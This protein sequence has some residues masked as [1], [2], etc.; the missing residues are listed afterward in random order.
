M[1]ITRA[2]AKACRI[3]FSWVMALSGYETTPAEEMDGVEQPRRERPRTVTVVPG[4][5]PQNAGR[6]F[7][8]DDPA[9]SPFWR[10]KIVKRDVKAGKTGDRT[11]TLH[12][13]TA[14]DGERFG[15]FDTKVDELIVANEGAELEIAWELSGKGNKN[16]TEVRPVAR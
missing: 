6:G 9:E 7:H 13:Y 4:P 5:A 12:T 16:I 10:G 15:T 2:T 11:W 3:A 14:A 1:A 8:D